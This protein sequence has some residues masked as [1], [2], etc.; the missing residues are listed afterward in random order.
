MNL[1]RRSRWS[2]CVAGI[3]TA[4]LLAGS[5]PEWTYA[6][7]SAG[8]ASRLDELLRDAETAAGLF[9]TGKLLY[10]TDTTKKEWGDYCRNS[11][12]LANQGEFRQAVREA[13]KALFLGQNSSNA[14]A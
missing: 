8:G 10:G 7:A 4:I 11:L 12:T 5:L 13:S 6:Q 9:A 2:R 3:F 1:D 14:T